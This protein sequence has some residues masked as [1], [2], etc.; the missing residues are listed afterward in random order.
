VAPLSWSTRG[1]A[2][3]VGRDPRN[4]T[5][6]RAMERLANAGALS[7]S[8]DGNRWHAAPKLFH[9]DEEPEP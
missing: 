6:R 8:G 9:D 2:Q 7:R 1:L 5:F 4:G 3:A